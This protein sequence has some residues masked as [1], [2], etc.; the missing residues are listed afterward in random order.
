MREGLKRAIVGA[1]M[2][3]LGASCGGDASEDHEPAA[4]GAAIMTAGGAEATCSG[5]AACGSCGAASC[6]S[7]DAIRLQRELRTMQRS[8]ARLQSRASSG[9][10]TD[11]EATERYREVRPGD[12]VATGDDA[13]ATF[14]IDV[15]TGSY[16]LARSSLLTHGQL[17]NP[18]GVR[19]EEFVNYF[20]YGPPAATNDPFHV[21]FESGPSA[22]G[23]DGMQLLRVGVQARAIEASARRP[24][25]L[26]FLVDVSGSMQGPDRIGLVQ[27]ALARL[28]DSLAPDDTVGIVVY[29]SGEGVLLPPTPVANRARILRAVRGL[30]AGGSTAGEAGIRAA[31]DMALA[32]LRAGGINRVI[33]CTDGDF[34]VGLTGDELVHAVE[35]FRDRDVQLTTLGFGRGNYND[36]DLERMADRGNGN[37]AYID[38]RN[39]AIRVLA[40]DLSGTISVVASDVKVQVLFDPA[41]V[42]RYRLVGYDNRVLEDHEFDDDTVDAAEIGSGQRAT[43][44]LEYELAEGV[45]PRREPNRVLAEVLVRYKPPG[46]ETSELLQYDVRLRD[47]RPRLEDTSEAFRLGAS[48]AE[49]AEI[50]RRSPHASGARWADVARI[51][52]GAGAERSDEGRELLR[53]ID[54]ARGLFPE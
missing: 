17:P 36:G 31:Y 52:R 45:R 43:A 23:E 10:A 9:S 24:A 13:I 27:F 48:V 11:P 2:A 18:A 3:S 29:A 39:E 1:A 12:F 8:A 47:V 28:V 7:G 41:T 37:Y 16:S 20:R 21:E 38:G 51:A 6:G 44:F 40:R 4:A 54:A 30:S 25:N 49:L 5:A 22:F 42:S 26:V 50:L 33:W 53:M 19:V 46:A 32:N 35:S 34:N 14:S 15:D